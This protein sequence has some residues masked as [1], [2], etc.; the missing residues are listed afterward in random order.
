MTEGQAE[1]TTERARSTD[2]CVFSCV[3]LMTTDI[4][5]HAGQLKPFKCSE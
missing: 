2:K 4:L 3:L 1:V 5:M